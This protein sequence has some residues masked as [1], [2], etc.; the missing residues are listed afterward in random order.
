MGRAKSYRQLEQ[1][2]R[3]EKGCAER[4]VSLRGTPAAKQQIADLQA[5]FEADA[6]LTPAQFAAYRYRIAEY[7]RSGSPPAVQASLDLEPPSCA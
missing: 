1:L 5:H 7:G 3:F 4:L 6:T 2:E